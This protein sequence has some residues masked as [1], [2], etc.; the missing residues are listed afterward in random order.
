[1]STIWKRG[2][3]AAALLVAAACAGAGG[4]KST[5]GTVKQADYRGPK[6]GA[7]GGGPATGGDVDDEGERQ[8]LRD[9]QTHSERGAAA[10]ESGNG[11]QARAEFRAAAQGFRELADT[12]RHSDWRIVYR[13]LAAEDFRRSGDLEDAARQAEEIRNDPAAN[14]VSKA[15]S[16]RLAAG[17]WQA[18]GNAEAKAGRLEP[19]K[20]VS[21]AQRRGQKPN[22]RP[23]ELPWQRFVENSDVYGASY[24]ADADPK[25]AEYA[26]ALAYFA[27][28]AQFSHDNV[29]EAQK[30]LDAMLKQFPHTEHAGDAVALYL[31]TYAVQGD[32]A[33]YRAALLR[34]SQQV[35]Q[36]A[37][38]AQ[39]KAA[40]PNAPPAAKE[41]ADRMAK[42]KEQI[43]QD[44]KAQG[45]TEASS[46]LNAG[47]PAEAAA[48][49]ER[50]AQESP[51]SPEAA[52]A[53]YNA[54]VAW[55]RAEQPRKATA[56]REQ[57]LQRYGDSRMAAPAT[58]SLAAGRSRAGDHAGAAELYGKFLDRWPDSE[59]RCLALQNRGAES[60]AAGKK[61][62]AAKQLLEFGKDSAC[63]K[64][65]PNAAARSL[66]T[67][68][69]TLYEL[70][71]KDQ[72]KD[73]W[74]ALV[75]VPGVTDTVAKS[76]V[77][78]AQARLKALK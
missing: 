56:A 53:L 6:S 39:Q 37:Q 67:A 77:A 28:V 3:L 34:V 4:A 16:A 76:Q 45:F 48:A 71:R 62:T 41:Q 52:T 66:Y 65:D 23:L 27:A 13:R 40:A 70:K 54:G 33:G 74:A 19:L 57:L 43:A 36:L 31:Q 25:A 2:C 50:F 46:L 10:Q 58:L 29:E 18:F 21:A 9:A 59:N 73:A 17:L 15:F 51:D 60:F 12:Y 72:A 22:P 26:G 49:F 78:D 11:D 5:A 55:D 24:K 69:A 61:E 64:A 44:Q 75:R 42:L 32:Q 7:A 63:A 38:E 1:M 14:D 20:V 8:R 47:K 68:G 30:R 35:D